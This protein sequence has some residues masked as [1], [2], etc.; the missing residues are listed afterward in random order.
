A[1]PFETLLES[2]CAASGFHIVGKPHHHPHGA[3]ASCPLRICRDRP[4][5]DCAADQS[6]ELA[7]AH[8][9]TRSGAARRTFRVTLPRCVPHPRLVTRS[10][11]VG[12][13]TGRSGRSPPL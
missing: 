3:Y 1:L 6:N 4:A 8:S 11:F 7:A 5:R 9:L 10:H 13:P 12:T 2:H